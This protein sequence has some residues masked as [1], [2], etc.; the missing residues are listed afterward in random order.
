M[1][2]V[3]LTGDEQSA[4]RSAWGIERRSGCR[5]STRGCEPVPSPR[6]PTG[7]RE[8]REI[9]SLHQF[10]EGR[11]QGELLADLIT[12]TTQSPHPP[13]KPNPTCYSSSYMEQHM[14][15]KKQKVVA[16][17]SIGIAVLSFLGLIAIIV[18]QM[19]I[20]FT[21]NQA[22]TFLGGGELEVLTASIFA[23]VLGL[24]YI[25]R[26]DNNK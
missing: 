9:P 1:N 13:I 5:P 25:H 22:F 4:G 14:R 10:L 23:L 20:R 8:A 16:F 15:E 12:C 17:L 21:T 11:R 7:S 3:N 24:A 2:E 19:D 6:L 18:F 26:P